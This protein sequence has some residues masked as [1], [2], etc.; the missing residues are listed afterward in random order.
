MNWRKTRRAR[1]FGW[2]VLTTFIWGCGASS[3]LP[4]LVPVTGQVTMGGKPLEEA[5][6][7]FVP[8]KGGVSSGMT[9]AEGKFE[10]YYSGGHEGAV[11]GRHTVRISKMKG[12]A[13]EELIPPKFN[14]ASTITKDVTEAGPNEFQIDL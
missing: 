12:E 6:V 3:D 8:E 13:G 2:A 14:E 1:L 9:D 5:N 4:T 7:T 11:P 10:L